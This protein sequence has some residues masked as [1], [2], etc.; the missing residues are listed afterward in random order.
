MTG[1]TTDKWINSADAVKILSENSG[2]PVARQYI[3]KL[4]TRGEIAQKRIDGRT[5][6]YNRRQ[7]EAYRVGTTPGRRPKNIPQKK[8]E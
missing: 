6:L 8:D 1:A 3:R 7:V 2:H 5:Y 4:A